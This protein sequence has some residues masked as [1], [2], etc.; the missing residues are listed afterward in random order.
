MK[1]TDIK[2]KTLQD[3]ELILFR[4]NIIRG[5]ISSIMGD[6]YVKPD[7]KKDMN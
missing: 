6:C 7:E 3:K 2:L 4:E 1:Y 5:G